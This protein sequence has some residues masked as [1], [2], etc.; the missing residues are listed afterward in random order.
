[1]SVQIR[2]LDELQP[3]HELGVTALRYLAFRELY[4]TDVLRTWK[5]LGFPMAGYTALYAVDGSQVLATVEVHRPWFTT[6]EGTS[7]ATGLAYVSTRPH[8]TRRGLATRLVSEVIE[9]QRAEGDL[10]ALL[11]CGRHHVSHAVYERVGFSDVWESPRGFRR[12]AAGAKLPEGYQ[13]RTARE[14][15]LPV[16]EE[17]RDQMARGRTGFARRDPGHLTRFWKSDQLPLEE[18][19][20]LEEH[21]RPVGYATLSK[22]LDGFQGSEN[23]VAEERHRDPL[24]RALEARAGGKWLVLGASPYSWWGPVLH[25][26]GYSILRDSFGALMA[27][28]LQEAVPVRKRAAQLGSDR[29]GFISLSTDN[30]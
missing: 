20:V 28:P 21:G 16:L 9:R 3:E 2:T 14:E 15:D 6:P 4:G 10:W 5:R 19:V 8:A 22:N 18:L 13:E 23:V 30:F 12:V 29:E 11:W 26:R 17:L 7:R 25:E 24:L 1:M 27:Y